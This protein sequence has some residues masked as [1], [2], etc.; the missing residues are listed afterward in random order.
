MKYR[1]LFKYCFV[2]IVLWYYVILYK[3]WVIIIELNLFILKPYKCRIKFVLIMI[4]ASLNAHKKSILEI[5]Y[6]YLYMYTA[7]YIVTRRNTCDIN[8]LCQ[9]KILS[10]KRNPLK[11]SV[12]KL[13]ATSIELY[14]KWEFPSITSTQLAAYFLSS[15]FVFK[16]TA[17]AE[18]RFILCN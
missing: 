5:K 16:N 3:I 11:T 1:F 12:L 13:L 14:G 17:S 15:D 8:Y 2:N 6:S 9:Y 4:L 18:Q 7:N 10:N